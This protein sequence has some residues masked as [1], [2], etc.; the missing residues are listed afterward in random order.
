MTPSLILLFKG[1]LG[2]GGGVGALIV[3]IIVILYC[4]RKDNPRSG[5]DEPNGFQLLFGGLAFRL[6]ERY[7]RKTEKLVHSKQFDYPPSLLLKVM[8]ALSGVALWV[9]VILFMASY[10][11]SFLWVW[12]WGIF[13]PFFYIYLYM[14]WLKYFFVGLGKF[15]T[16]IA[17]ALCILFMLLVVVFWIFAIKAFNY[18]T[19]LDYMIQYWERKYGVR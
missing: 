15:K 19:S 8:M 16:P 13:M 10:D 18:Y 5:S 17:I 4:Y 2:V 12:L 3:A 14:L 6:S 11:I 7:E 1:G 9:Y